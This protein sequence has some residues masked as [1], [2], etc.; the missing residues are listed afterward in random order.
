MCILQRYAFVVA[1]VL[2]LVAGIHAPH[3]LGTRIYA[4]LL[5]LA[6][7]LG[8]GVAARQSWMQRF[9]SKE[10]ECGPGLEYMLDSFPL[11]DA[12]PMIFK[13]GGDCSK[14]QWTFLGGS[15]PEWSLVWFALFALAAA[16]ILVKASSQPR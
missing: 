12:L 2:A 10:M 3:R 5:L 14:V 16:Y 9:P 11:T 8:G 1:A 15:I 7:L 4:V 6:S 13:G